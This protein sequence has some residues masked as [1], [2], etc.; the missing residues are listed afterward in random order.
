MTSG[1][2]GCGVVERVPLTLADLTE[3][4]QYIPADDRDTWLQVGM[5][6]KAEFASAGFDAWDTWSASGAG[7][8]AGDAK[9]VCRHVLGE[10][11]GAAVIGEA[12]GY[13]TAA[14]VHMAKG[15]PVAMAL[16]AG[17]MPAVARDLA[18]QCPDALLVVAGDDDPTKPGNPG[19][20][21]A[22]AAAGEVGGIAAFPTQPAEGGAGQDWNDVHV[23][24]GLEAVAQQ[25]DAAVAAGKPSPTPSTDEAA[26]PAGSSD[27]GGQGAGFTPEQVL[28]R[29]AL[30][31]GTTQVHHR[32]GLQRDRRQPDQRG[33][34]N[35]RH[36]Q[37]LRPQPDE[38]KARREGDH[39][40]RRLAQERPDAA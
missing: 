39:R 4:L 40:L 22:E 32:G 24:W 7:Y 37:P 1:M 14:S 29:F 35:W 18:A 5:G 2:R 31:E 33:R 26:A 11:D 3:L 36:R 19:R 8:N 30:V 25:L 27:N 17:N 10:L 21:K 23:A 28:R 38:R 34:L 9:T 12:E 13:A 16:D 15:W 6:I 20:K